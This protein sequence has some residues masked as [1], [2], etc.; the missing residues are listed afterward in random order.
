M[1]PYGRSVAVSVRVGLYLNT[2]W[3]AL[4]TPVLLRRELR[5]DAINL[6]TPWL[7]NHCAKTKNKKQ[8]SKWINVQAALP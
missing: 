1:K 6:H 3:Y 4:F 5:T 7:V 2:E 8:Q